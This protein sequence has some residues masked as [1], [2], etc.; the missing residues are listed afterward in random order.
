MTMNEAER[1]LTKRWVDAW[2]TAGP[3][4]QKVRDDDIRAADTA[5]MIECCDSLF[6][7]AVKNFPPGPTSGLVEQQHWFMKLRRA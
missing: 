6:R 4:L 5:G 7:D 3:E 2:A 1:E